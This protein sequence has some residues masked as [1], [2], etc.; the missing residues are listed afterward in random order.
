MLLTSATS[1][2]GIE[3]L[4]EQLS[5]RTSILAGLSGVGKSSLLNAVQP[6]LQL[7]TGEISERLKMGRHTTTQVNLFKLDL[8]GYVIDTPGIRDFGLA[9][10]LRTDLIE[11]YPEHPGSG[12]DAAG[13]ATARTRTNLAALSKPPCKQASSQRHAT[14][15][16]CRSMRR[17]PQTGAKA[18]AS[19]DPDLALIE[20]AQEET[21]KMLIRQATMEDYPE[22]CAVL[23]EVDAQHRE[24]L[25]QVFRDPGDVARSRAYIASIVEDETPACGS[26]STR[27]RSWVSCT[28]RSERRATSR[29][30]CP[31]GTQ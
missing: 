31:G 23:D 22:L 20:S 25:P 19:P 10:L 27:N 15:A 7:R 28:S 2:I 26:Q 5:G 30:S 1:N 29:S 16:T 9:G 8:G 3:E 12:C 17:C 13:S 6:G 11:Y 21:S 24:A 14:R 4:R 18:R